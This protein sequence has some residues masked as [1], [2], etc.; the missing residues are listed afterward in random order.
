M[1]MEG[2]SIYFVAVLCTVQQ[3]YKSVSSVI[4][5]PEYILFFYCKMSCFLNFHLGYSLLVCRNACD[6]L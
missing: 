1:N 6:F 2:F 4:F 3:V 5:I